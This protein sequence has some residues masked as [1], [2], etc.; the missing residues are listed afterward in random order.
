MLL[1]SLRDD[2]GRKAI[3]PVAEPEYTN[4]VRFTVTGTDANKQKAYKT[5]I[6]RPNRAPRVNPNETPIIPTLVIGTQEA[7]TKDLEG[8]KSA[9]GFYPYLAALDDQTDTQYT[10]AHWAFPPV[11]CSMFNMC[12]Q[13]LVRAAYFVDEGFDSTGA[14]TRGNLTFTGVVNDSKEAASLAVADRDAEGQNGLMF[15]GLKSSWDKDGGAD[16]DGAHNAVEVRVTATDGGGLTSD[17]ATF[18]VIVNAG[19]KVKATVG[20]D[21]I[22]IGMPA[23]IKLGAMG[24]AD[25]FFEDAE[26][27]T[28]TYTA[29]TK[30][31]IVGTATVTVDDSVDP[32]T[33]TITGNVP[34][35]VE[36]TL[37][38]TEA[39]DADGDV[40]V[41]GDGF[42]HDGLGQWAQQTFTVTVSR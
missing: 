32:K 16:G 40:T 15:T 8:D 13:A 35:T 3:K 10:T 12:V 26:N 22:K 34:G 42:E 5:F 1:V 33:L 4:D 28:L 24:G 9:D 23:V 7:S 29:G 39:L 14:A 37:R 38:A 19:P 18:N 36:V 30:S 6:I 25:F 11:D 21:A 41:D 2:A 20:N 31:S 17:S 27:N